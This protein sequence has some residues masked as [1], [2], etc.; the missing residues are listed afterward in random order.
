MKSE[1]LAYN[2]IHEICYII[3]KYTAEGLVP[4]KDFWIYYPP[5]INYIWGGI[6]GIAKSNITGAIL[7]ESV[8]MAGTGLACFWTARKIFK[9]DRTPYIVSFLIVFIIH[10]RFIYRLGFNPDHYTLLPIV[11]CV[12]AFVDYLKSRKFLSLLISGLAGAS[13][14]LIKQPTAFVGIFCYVFLFLE[15]LSRRDSLGRILKAS[16]WL[17]AGFAVPFLFFAGLMFSLDALVPMMIQLADAVVWTRLEA[18]IS[19]FQHWVHQLRRFVGQASTVF[20]LLVPVTYVMSRRRRWAQPVF[21]F[22]VGVMLVSYLQVVAARVPQSYY[23]MQWMLLLVLLT[24]FYWDYRFD[25]G[26][27]SHALIQSILGLTVICCLMFHF[28]TLS[29]AL[30]GALGGYSHSK[31]H[32]Q[33]QSQQVHRAMQLRRH[34]DPIVTQGS[35]IQYISEGARGILFFGRALSLSPYIF[36]DARLVKNLSLQAYYNF[37]DYFIVEQE[38]VDSPKDSN[39]LFFHPSILKGYKKLDKKYG[40]YI[41]YRQN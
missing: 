4:Y 12:G 11:I 19:P 41:F 6:Y 22:L 15:G 7:A 23:F 24:G 40:Y 3:G 32:Y 30:K 8:W 16:L 33:S 35:T 29:D 9:D 38:V 36:E 39:W 31:R 26:R 14:I 2:L 28:L 13:A 25:F 27:K 37:P 5:L 34:M 18:T 21:L 20:F 17:S 1:L 10:L